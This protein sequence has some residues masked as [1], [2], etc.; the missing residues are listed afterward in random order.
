[1]KKTMAIRKLE[2]FFP[3]VDTDATSEQKKLSPTPLDIC[4]NTRIVDLSQ[5]YKSSRE[6]KEEKFVIIHR[7]N[8]R[9]WKTL[10]HNG[11]SK[12]NFK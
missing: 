11:H 8:S 12:S 3:V 5:K 1:M 7:T 9:F 10:F 6:T 4:E 2:N